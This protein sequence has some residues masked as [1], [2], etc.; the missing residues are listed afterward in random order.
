[1][2]YSPDIS[3]IFIAQHHS[4]PFP[5][6]KPKSQIRGAE[7]VEEGGKG[8]VVQVL[9]GEEKKREKKIRKRKFELRRRRPVIKFDVPLMRYNRQTAKR[10]G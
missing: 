5:R 3:S 7:R 8:D 1:M 4:P 10:K 6:S 2:E 9:R